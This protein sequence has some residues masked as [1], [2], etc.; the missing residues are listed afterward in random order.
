MESMSSS[1]VDPVDPS[2]AA[3]IQ[4]FL[5]GQQRT[6]TPSEMYPIQETDDSLE[7]LLRLNSDAGSFFKVYVSAEPTGKESQT[8]GY[9]ISSLINTVESFADDRLSPSLGP[10]PELTLLPT[11]PARSTL[12]STSIDHPPLSGLLLP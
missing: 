5:T 11:G 8:D 3:M 10:D 12:M 4:D 2:T 6:T 1:P 7:N 9:R